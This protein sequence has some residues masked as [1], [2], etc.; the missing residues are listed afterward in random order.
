LDNLKNN[1]CISRS[2][3]LIRISYKDKRKIVNILQGIM[4]EL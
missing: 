1:Y 2:I 3:P 4:G